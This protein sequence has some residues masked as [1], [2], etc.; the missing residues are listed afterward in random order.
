MILPHTA[1]PRFFSLVLMSFAVLSLILASFG[2][3]GVVSH[4]V[5]TRVSEIGIRVALG[6][7]RTGVVKMVVWEGM[8]PVLAG[9][10]IGL[11]AAVAVTRV[12]AS[13]LFGVSPW[14][15]VTFL[16]VPPLLLAAALLACWLPAGRAVRMDPTQALRTE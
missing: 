15:P 8:R 6:A 2:V 14:N 1:Q 10:G 5:S 3:Y 16:A 9:A 7:P 12:M 4:S 11:L 13:M